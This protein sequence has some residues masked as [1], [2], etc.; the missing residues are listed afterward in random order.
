MV[1]RNGDQS[2]ADAAQWILRALIHAEM[3]NIT[4]T[5]AYLLEAIT[6]PVSSHGIDFVSALEAARNYGEIYARNM[7]DV[8]KERIEPTLFFK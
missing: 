1:T 6:S 7:Q 8:A 2:F 3:N 5:D 4:Q